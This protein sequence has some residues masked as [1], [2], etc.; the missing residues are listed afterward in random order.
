[1]CVNECMRVTV[2]SYFPSLRIIDRA[3]KDEIK[4]AGGVVD[5]PRRVY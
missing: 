4:V 3:V 2:Q 1:M 5:F